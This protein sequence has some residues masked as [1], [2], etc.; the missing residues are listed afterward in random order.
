VRVCRID[1]DLRAR[2]ECK[3]G[4]ARVRAQS[5]ER[6]IGTNGPERG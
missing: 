3:T 1:D 2:G 4:R 6:T 5:H